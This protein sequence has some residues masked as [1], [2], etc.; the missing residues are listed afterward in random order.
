MLTGV[1]CVDRGV[2]N[3]RGNN[4]GVLCVDRGV[5]RGVGC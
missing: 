4:R 5:D 2:G 1:S 3:D